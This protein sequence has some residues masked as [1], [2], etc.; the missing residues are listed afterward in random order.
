[1]KPYR[2]HTIDALRGFASLA[3]CWFHLTSGYAENSQVRS[4]GSYGWLGVEVFFVLSGFIIPFAMY[5]GG[6]T[7]R[8]GWKTFISKR[9]LRIE[10]PYLV[11]ILLVFALWHLSSMAPGFKGSPP[12]DFISMQT[13][14]HV[15]YL[16]GVAGHPWLNPVFWTL[17]IEFQFYLL[18]SLIF[19]WLQHR[20]T[21]IIL[22]IDLIL[23]LT[24][25]LL[26]S[27][28][29]VFRF[30]GLF[31]LGIVAFQYQIKLLTGKITATLLIA[32]TLTIGLSLGWMIALVGLMTSILIALNVSLGNHKI[33]AWL[34]A[35]S[36]SLYLIHIPIG[37]RLV[38]LGKRYIESQVGELFLS[39][40]ALGLSLIVAHIFYLVIER[41]SQHLAAQLK[42]TNPV[43]N[44]PHQRHAR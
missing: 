42:Y 19:G 34:G 25:L 39:I 6:Y 17:A 33:T 15:G 7:F 21:Q 13:L 3:V 22:L 35:I 28:L 24:S 4:S 36:F 1:M 14:L 30:L 2:L 5:S 23:L 26:S 16:A 18:V 43:V 12:P 41:P 10:P 40:L 20:T 9:I 11:T 37:G 38:N 32:T 8:G 29:F 31:V 44:Q 27:E